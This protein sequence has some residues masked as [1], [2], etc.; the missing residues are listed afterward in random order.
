MEDAFNFNA[1]TPLQEGNGFAEP[2][3]LAALD[4]ARV[5]KLLQAPPRAH[6]CVSYASGS[7]EAG[8]DSFT[9]Y[10]FTEEYNV[11]PGE[12][13]TIQ[14]RARKRLRFSQDFSEESDESDDE[15]VKELAHFSEHASH[16]SALLQHVQHL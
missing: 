11:Q 1:E 15:E 13:E 9:A 12:S 7:F 4:S 10:G 5:S 3:N 14:G 16:L 6:P 2:G 8:N